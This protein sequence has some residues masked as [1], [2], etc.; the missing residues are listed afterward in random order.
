MTVQQNSTGAGIQILRNGG[1][2]GNNP[3]QIQSTSGGTQLA[4]SSS[5][6]LSIGTSTL[7]VA[8]S[9]LDVIIGKSGAGSAATVYTDGGSTRWGFVYAN[10]SQM[11]YGSFG[12][13]V[14]ETGSTASEKMRIYPAGGVVINGSATNQTLTT[15]DAGTN[16]TNTYLGTGQLRVG[17]GS[18]HGSNTVLSVAPGVVTFDRPGIGGGALTI[19]SN[20]QLTLPSQPSFLAV[21][22]AS[23]Q[24]YSSG[25]VILFNLTRHNTGGHYNTSNG[26]FTAPTGGRYL[27]SV[28]FY[29][30]PSTRV[31]LTLTINGAQYTPSDL[32]PLLYKETTVGSVSSGFTLIFE[33][34]AGDYVEVRSRAGYTTNVYMSHSHFTGQL[35]S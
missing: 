8:S 30:Y 26:R 31:S 33:L 17:G 2:W 7:P 24:N 18:D 27:F 32:V 23:E 1:N 4:V 13:I 5:G 11:S 10:A 20:G 25:Q 12:A 9:G 22:N 3:F 6:I 16:R 34:S 19:N 29:T 15:G 35:L 21:S 28:N 14:F